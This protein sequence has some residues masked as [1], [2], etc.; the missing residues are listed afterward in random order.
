MGLS[1]TRSPE[2][3]VSTISK[4][5]INLYDLTGYQLV[6]TSTIN[7]TRFLVLIEQIKDVIKYGFILHILMP[8]VHFF[9]YIKISTG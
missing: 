2:Y 1:Y 8:H 3:P 7:S 9:K 5:K 4:D 6:A